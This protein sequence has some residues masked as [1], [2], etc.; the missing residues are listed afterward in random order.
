MASRFLNLLVFYFV[1]EGQALLTRISLNKGREISHIRGLERHLKILKSQRNRL[2]QGGIVYLKDYENIHYYGEIGLGTPSQRFKVLFDTGSSNSWILSNKCQ[3]MACRNHRK[4]SSEKSSTFTKNGTMVSLQYAIGRLKGFLSTDNLELAGMNIE[5]Q[6]FIE[7]TK[8][9]FA[10]NTLFDGI[11]GLGYP[12]PAMRDVSTPIQN[13]FQQGH[14]HCVFSFYLKSNVSDNN[15]GEILFGGIDEEIVEKTTL[16]Y[17]PVTKKHHWQIAIDRV[18]VD[19]GPSVC[20]GG[21]Q[22]SVDTATSLIVGPIGDIHRINIAVGG[23]TR[24][25][26]GVH[27]VDCDS[28]ASLPAVIFTI[29]GQDFQLKGEDYVF[30]VTSEDGISCLSGFMGMNLPNN[31]WILGH[32]FIKNFYTVFDMDES[33]I[34]FGKLKNEQKL[35]KVE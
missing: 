14:G 25:I 16:R 13:I 18:T 4:Y 10:C 1:M 30:K 6:T 29:N 11:V 23:D 20:D 26:S 3:D 12:S 34:G 21:C 15:A 2:D 9:N 28:I 5:N 7:V 27:T 33:R 8:K 24:A 19:D 17:S 35:I 22:A 31:T 32:T